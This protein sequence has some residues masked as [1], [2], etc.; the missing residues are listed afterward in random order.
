MIRSP[1]NNGAQ[2]LPDLAKTAVAND[3]AA[4]DKGT[5]GTG[6]T[7][8]AGTATRSYATEVCVVIWQ[9]THGP[10][11]QPS[12][13]SFLCCA[14]ADLG[15]GRARTSNTLAVNRILNGKACLHHVPFTPLPE[16]IHGLQMGCART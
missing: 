14:V 4:E 2:S 15:S 11:A 9:H 8:A 1:I 16:L 12:S 5:F 3:L 6:Y 13:I 10:Q 7:F